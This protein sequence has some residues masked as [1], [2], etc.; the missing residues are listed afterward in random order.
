MAKTKDVLW[1]AER[2]ALF[3][4]IN[5]PREAKNFRGEYDGF[6]PPHFWK[7]TIPVAPDD[8]IPEED[9]IFGLYGTDTSGALYAMGLK[10]APKSVLFWWWL[11]QRIRVA[12][13]RGFPREMCVK[14]ICSTSR[15]V[16]FFQAWPYQN[17]LMFLACEAWRAR[18][19]GQCGERFVA[20]K[21]A[22][23]FC[24][25]RCSAQA[26]RVSRA[27]SWEKHGDEWRTRHSEKITRSKA[28]KV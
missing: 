24:S 19:C 25:G 4:N 20:D 3:S 18:F 11:K 9:P 12:W 16:W 6:I 28:K 2:L 15:P 5:G 14:L 7:D 10:S 21:P 27:I 22:R 26:R 13:Q 8:P 17:A 23:R 1:D